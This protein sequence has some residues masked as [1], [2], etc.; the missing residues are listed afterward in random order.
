MNL[1]TCADC[2][3]WVMEKPDHG[4][5]RAHPP[6]VLGVHDETVRR[7]NL[8]PSSERPHTHC[9]EWCGEWK[10]NGG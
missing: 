3:W 8:V 9:D 5:C 10:H 7:A 1:G 4:V 6:S 2:F